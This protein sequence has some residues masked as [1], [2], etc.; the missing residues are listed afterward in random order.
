ML[1]NY[2]REILSERVFPF[3]NKAR[4]FIMR[5]SKNHWLVTKPVAHRGLWGGSVP[6]NSLLA[7]EKAAEKGY[8]V[9]IDVYLTADGRIVSF[10]DATLERMT[11]EKGFIWDKTFS[12]LRELRL[13]GSEY[14]VPTLEE[15]FSVC[16]GK[17]PLLIEIKDQPSGKEL[18]ALLVGKL[19]NYRGEFALQS[20]NPLYIAKVKKL[21]PQFIRGV[22]ATQDVSSLKNAFKRHIVKNMSLN[23]LAKPD[24]ISYDYRGYP[25]PDGKVRKKA[26]LAWTV[27]SYEVWDKI[28]PYVDNIIFEGIT[29][30]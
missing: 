24:F 22:L 15:V 19:K 8:P 9:E 26:C 1:I 23:F 25:L 7:Y 10:H 18:T 11:G 29:I 21:A 3:P 20:F 12:E 16:E 27:T 30:D 4:R 6:E 17:S 5:I 14:T 2:K 13:N 28:K